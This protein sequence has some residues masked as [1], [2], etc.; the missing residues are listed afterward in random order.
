MRLL[1]LLPLRAG[2]RG[3]E[4]SGGRRSSVKPS[5]GG[6]GWPSREAGARGN[7]AAGGKGSRG[8]QQRLGERPVGEAGWRRP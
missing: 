4:S 1:R 6:G 5:E 7:G 3:R 8:A 2:G